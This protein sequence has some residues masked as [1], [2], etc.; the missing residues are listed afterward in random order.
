MT[1]IKNITPVVA[2]AEMKL[3]TLEQPKTAKAD[4]NQA[5]KTF[6]QNIHTKVSEELKQHTKPEMTGTKISTKNSKSEV[7]FKQSTKSINVASC[8]T[9]GNIVITKTITKTITKVIKPVTEKT[10]EQ[11]IKNFLKSTIRATVKTAPILIGAVIGAG[12]G[13]M[14]LPVAGTLIGFSIG[15]K[16]G[17]NISKKCDALLFG[18]SNH[19]KL[20]EITKKPLAKNSSKIEQI[21]KKETPHTTTKNA[22]TPA[23]IRNFGAAGNE[24]RTEDETLKINDKKSKKS[25]QKKDN[26]KFGNLIAS[27]NN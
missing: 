13:G 6:S 27:S 7:P 18:K 20:G 3:S 19:N 14:V 4:T 11:K 25:H 21:V 9:K 22:T 5:N 8:K 12:I 24:L 1:V 26:H 10:T 23:L 17:Y 15:A 2:K 16:M